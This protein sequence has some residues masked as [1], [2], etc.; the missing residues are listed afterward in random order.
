MPA[1]SEKHPNSSGEHRI[2]NDTVLGI[3]RQEACLDLRRL[4]GQLNV[5]SRNAALIMVID[6]LRRTGKLQR[7][8]GKGRHALFVLSTFE[9]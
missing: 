7:I 2:S 3:F 6:K 9:A 5:D 4:A 8:G 1:Q